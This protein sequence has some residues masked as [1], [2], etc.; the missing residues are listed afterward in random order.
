MSESKKGE[1]FKPYARIVKEGF[2]NGKQMFGLW[3]N[4]KRLKRSVDFYKLKT[5]ADLLNKQLN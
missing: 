3:H 4:G 5:E 1:N 2:Q